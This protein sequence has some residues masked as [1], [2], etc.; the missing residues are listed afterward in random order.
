MFRY[1]MA[2]AWKIWRFFCAVAVGMASIVPILTE[3]VISD[4]AFIHFA[5]IVL[6]LGPLPCEFPLE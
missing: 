4:N 5:S 3:G 6:D 1:I 2:L